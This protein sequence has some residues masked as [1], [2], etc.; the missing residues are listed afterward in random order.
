MPNNTAFT[1]YG[2][3]V[4]HAR[5]TK[6]I[7]EILTKCAD[8]KYIFRGTPQV[9]SQKEDG[10]NSSLYRWA[11]DNDVPLNDYFNPVDIEKEIVEKAKRY[12]PPNTSNIEILT[13]LRHYGGNVTL[14]DFSRNLYVALFFA[15]NGN[16][17]KDGELIV[18]KTDELKTIKEIGYSKK[19]SQMRVIE[20]ANTQTSQRRTISQSSV[21]VVAPNGYIE[22]RSC[23]TLEIVK[24]ERELKQKIMEHLRI[25][26][27]ISSDTIYNDLIGFIA[28]EENDTTAG[29][30]FYK[31]LAKYKEGDSRVAID[32]Y[33]K[34]IEL[35]PQLA[36]AYNN[37]S[38]AKHALEH[39]EEVIEDCNKAIELN[40]QLA[41]AY[42]NRG[43]AKSAL[44]KHEEAIEDFSKAIELNPQLAEVYN[45]RGFAKY[46]KEHNRGFANFDLLQDVIED[47]NKAIELN[48]QYAEA[49]YNRGNAKSDLS[50]NA[51]GIEDYNKAIKLN[52]QYAKAYHN[53]GVAKY[54]LDQ[55]AEAIED[56]TRAIELDPQ[57]VEAYY[58]RGS[59]KSSL[60]Q[61]AEAIEDYTKAIELDPQ[62]VWAYHARGNA[63]SDLG[64]TEEAEKDY[65]KASEL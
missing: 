60:G 28:N 6:L 36:E 57:D 65:D 9:H 10:I 32:H 20:P 4:R 11:K 21:F 2:D 29:S 19:E 43:F 25:F 27:N 12:F 51:G 14:I 15:C 23:R 54:F 8:G 64:Q 61:K 63:K 53:R 55:K 31:G 56:Y 59:A 30:E 35:N 48:P 42:N 46:A 1:G 26:H 50:K 44:E 49:Y 41:E 5:S 18:L 58:N 62:D 3:L 7:S 24:I 16:F 45:N 34:A 37:R 22:E 13:D 39:Y 40:P 47:Y 17:N 38:L 33:D 52:P